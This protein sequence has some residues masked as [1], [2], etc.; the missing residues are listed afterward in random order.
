MKC[1][2]C[3]TEISE[4]AT[5]CPNCKFD[6]LRYEFINAKEVDNY[7]EKTVEPYGIKWKE[8]SKE[9][10]IFSI[11]LP[12]SPKRCMNIEKN[13]I[14]YI[15]D[16][17]YTVIENEEHVKITISFITHYDSHSKT[18]IP[19][20]DWEFATQ[21][22]IIES[23]RWKGKRIGRKQTGKIEIAIPNAKNEY[24]FSVIERYK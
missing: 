21:N 7:I 6:D 19:F 24:Q 8:S 13:Y 23:G 12:T 20:F 17:K 3:K 11:V 14:W 10:N 18:G 16:F 15:S 4:S 5:V 9:D 1:P 22:T 2:V